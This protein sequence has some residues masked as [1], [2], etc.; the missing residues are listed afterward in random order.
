MIIQILKLVEK[1]YFEYFYIFTTP[2][3]HI[4]KS[5]TDSFTL[6]LIFYK[7]ILHS[8]NNKFNPGQDFLLL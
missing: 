4:L 7:F 1:R 6:L 5:K 2:K 8:I 3:F